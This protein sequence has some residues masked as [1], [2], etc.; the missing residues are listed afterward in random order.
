DRDLG[1]TRNVE[2]LLDEESTGDNETQRDTKDRHKRDHRV[3]QRMTINHYPF[4]YAFRPGGTHII[5]AQDLQHTGAGETCEISCSSCRQDKY[6]NKFELDIAPRILPGIAP[7]R[8]RPAKTGVIIQPDNGE[9]AEDSE[10]KR[11]QCEQDKHR[12]HRSRIDPA[13]GSEGGNDTQWD[14]DQHL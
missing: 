1:D 13:I 2:N 3:A 6:W 12:T 11:R 9:L 8:D 5:L 14:S 10:D 4:L 7:V